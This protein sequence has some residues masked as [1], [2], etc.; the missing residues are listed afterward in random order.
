MPAEA[1]LAPGW[2][3]RASLFF[4][5]TERAVGGLVRNGYESLVNWMPKDEHLGRNDRP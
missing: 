3:D 5:L 2:T 4:D 1:I